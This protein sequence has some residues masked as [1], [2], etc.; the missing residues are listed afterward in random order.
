[1]VIEVLETVGPLTDPTAQG[2]RAA[3]AFCLVLPPHPDDVTVEGS[4]LADAAE[5]PE[6]V[7][8]IAVTI[9]N[10]Y[11]HQAFNFPSPCGDNGWLDDYTAQVRDEPIALVVL[12]TCNA[13]GQT[14]HIK[15]TYRPRSSLLL[16]SDRPLALAPV[17]GAREPAGSHPL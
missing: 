13:A 10:L 5:G 2:G 8:T 14:Q 15:G 11:G 9:R 16:A 17:S 4:L 1:M 6:A 3:D 12:V 7:R